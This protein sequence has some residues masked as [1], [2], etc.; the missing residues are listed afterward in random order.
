MSKFIELP[1]EDG[2]MSL[3]NVENITTVS[4]H[5]GNVR[6]VFNVPRGEYVYGI[7]YPIS[8]EEVKA[9]LQD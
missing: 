6:V 2:T 4:P 9:L 8:Y 1:N 3:I 7:T 5:G